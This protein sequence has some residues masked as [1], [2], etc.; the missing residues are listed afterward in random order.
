MTFNALTGV[1][2]LDVILSKIKTALLNTGE[3]QNHITFP[4]PKYEFSVK[5][6]VYPK[7][8]LEGP[9]G[10]EVKGSDGAADGAPNV[11]ITKS[12]ILDTPDKARLDAGLPVPRANMVGGIVV[13]KVVVTDSKEKK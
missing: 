13:D 8:S 5:V 4:L 1:E 10:I 2:S 11:S 7:Q 3:F 6:W 9:P 12:E